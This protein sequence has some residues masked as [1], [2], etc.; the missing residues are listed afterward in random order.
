LRQRHHSD[1]DE[2]RAD[3]SS[4]YARSMSELPEGADATAREKD[5]QAANDAAMADLRERHAEEL[6]RLQAAEVPPSPSLWPRLSPCVGDVELN[7]RATAG[8]LVA[9]GTER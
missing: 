2:L 1:E 4:H 3:Q 9:R 7:A 6:R 5:L 8:G